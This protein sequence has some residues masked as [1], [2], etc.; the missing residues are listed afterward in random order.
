MQV[1]VGDAYTVLST[2]ICDMIFCNDKGLIV[3]YKI[4]LANN[5]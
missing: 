2:F 5:K 3:S 1:D 4:P